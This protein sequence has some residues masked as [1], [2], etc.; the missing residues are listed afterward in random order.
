V[1]DAGFGKRSSAYEY[2]ASGRGGLGIANI[3]LSPRNGS[4]VA[5]SFPVRPG[6][7]VMLVT[8]AGRLI[9]VPADQVRITGRQAMGVT[10]FRVDADEHVTSVFPVIENADDENGASEDE[11]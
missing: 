10:L 11:S 8:D 6:D 9:R 5:A 4:A 1:T 3:M 7:D 2:R